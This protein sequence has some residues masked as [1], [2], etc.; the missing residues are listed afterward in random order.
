MARWASTAEAQPGASAPRAAAAPQPRADLDSPN[1][2]RTLSAGPPVNP[3]CM[4]SFLLLYFLF[5]CFFFGVR[6]G[7]DND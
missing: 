6:R 5:S 7:V 1:S 2:G 3:Q 4:S